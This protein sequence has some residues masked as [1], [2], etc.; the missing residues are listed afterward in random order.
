MFESLI[1]AKQRAIQDLFSFGLLSRFVYS[2]VFA[3]TRKHI[4]RQTQTGTDRHTHR[5]RHTETESQ[6]HK[7]THKHTHTH[8]HKK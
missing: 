5:H 8:T 6:T 3:H 4:R 1:A 2:C 7:H